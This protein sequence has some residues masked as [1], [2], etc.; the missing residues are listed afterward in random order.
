MSFFFKETTFFIE[1][2]LFIENIKVKK[3]LKWF[4]ERK[5]K[6]CLLFI[7]WQDRLPNSNSR[8]NCENGNDNKDKKYL[9]VKFTFYI[10]CKIIYILNKT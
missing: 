6:I 8:K 10:E 3:N 2:E 5:I 9:A 4:Y 1:S 7:K